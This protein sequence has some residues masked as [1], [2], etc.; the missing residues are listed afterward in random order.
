MTLLSAEKNKNAQA[1]RQGE[2][3]SVQ[4][5][6]SVGDTKAARD[7][8]GVRGT[9]GATIAARLVFESVSHAYDGVSSVRDVSLTVEPGEV[10]CLLGHSGCGKTTLLRIAAGVERQRFGRV[11]IN[12]REIAGPSTFLPPEQRGIG[13]MF[14]DY[15]LFPHLS[16]L[17]NVRFGLTALPAGEAEREALHALDR[18]GLKSYAR[19]YPHALSGGEQQRVALARAI[20]PRPSVLLMD[21]PFSGLDRRMRDSVRD[22]TMAVL[23]ETRATCIMVTHDPEEALRMGDRIALMRRGK[24]VQLGTPDALYNKPV[25]IFAARF[26]S[27]L[28]ELEGQVLDGKVSTPLGAFPADGVK[29]GQPVNLCIRPQSVRI[30]SAGTGVAG[31]IVGRCFLGEVDHLDVAV[32]G[33]SQPLKARVRAGQGFKVGLDVTVAVEPNDVLLFEAGLPSNEGSA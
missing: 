8:W 12:D 4:V 9:A 29:D 27:E 5:G 19:D 3:D 22:E 16:I 10:L 14:Q 11:L 20:A 2:P 24:L 1:V 17:D 7:S 32:D 23:R 18:V 28:N 25:D 31:R 33:L 21:E 6:G 30:A 15:A 26:F 13:L